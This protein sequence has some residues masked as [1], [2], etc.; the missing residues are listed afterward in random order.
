[1]KVVAGS[2]GHDVMEPL[3]WGDRRGMVWPEERGAWQA[4]P[5]HI[6]RDYLVTKGRL[7]VVD[8]TAR[9]VSVPRTL[10]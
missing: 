6:D 3:T 1:M 10:D 5:V 8:L 9:N 2:H 7:R 4:G